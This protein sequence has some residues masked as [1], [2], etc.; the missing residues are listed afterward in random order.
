MMVLMSCGTE[1]AVSLSTQP[2]AQPP[3]QSE[4]AQQPQVLLREL[5]TRRWWWGKGTGHYLEHSAVSLAQLHPVTGGQWVANGH[6]ADDG[7]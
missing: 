5:A 4:A 3:C 1:D 2:L 6:A 7:L